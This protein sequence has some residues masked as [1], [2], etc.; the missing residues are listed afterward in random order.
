M[1]IRSVTRIGGPPTPAKGAVAGFLLGPLLIGIA[2]L[3]ANVD[4]DEQKQAATAQQY[5]AQ[6]VGT[7]TAKA[8][9]RGRE[10]LE[11]LYYINVRFEPPG[12]EVQQ[13]EC[14]VRG[15]AFDQYEQASLANPVPTKVYYDPAKPGDWR[16]VHTAELRS[17]TQSLVSWGF[18]LMGVGM[19]VLGAFA[20]RKWRR[21]D[22]VM[23]RR[24]VEPLP[25]EAVEIWRKLGLPVSEAGGRHVPAPWE[26]PQQASQNPHAPIDPDAALGGAPAFETQPSTQRKP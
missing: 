8:R 24:D 1:R 26:Q 21:G 16:S 4:S 19:L 7:R 20:F 10:T 25:P 5:D 13:R 18:G 17:S 23:S 14:E 2:I 9:S 11:T 22:T 6:V 3:V 15:A 12:Y